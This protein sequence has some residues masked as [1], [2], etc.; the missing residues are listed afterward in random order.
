[1]QFL[2]PGPVCAKRA[3]E[4]IM[5]RGGRSILM[6]QRSR[7]SHMHGDCHGTHL[8]MAGPSLELSQEPKG[9]GSIGTTPFLVRLRASESPPPVRRILA[10][11]ISI[12]RPPESH[13]VFQQ[14]RKSWNR[15]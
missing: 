5:F 10:F 13:R 15:P 8:I 2:S 6:L 7:V 3:A 9:R 1:M 14:V 4:S 12:A 11:R